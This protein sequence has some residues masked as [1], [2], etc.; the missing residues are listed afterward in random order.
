MAEYDAIITALKTQLKE[1]T[2][3]AKALEEFFKDV[4]LEDKSHHS[5]DLRSRLTSKAVRGHAVINYLASIKIPEAE[6]V[7]L[8]HGVHIL[9][10][11]LK[12]LCISLDGKS[13]DEIVR[14][15][16]STLDAQKQ[17]QNFNWFTP[18]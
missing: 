2:D 18:K 9:S 16:Q 17:N 11:S 3:T 12:R 7:S 4:I 10:T 5:T 1:S 13:R 14:L 6:G 8:A 15:F